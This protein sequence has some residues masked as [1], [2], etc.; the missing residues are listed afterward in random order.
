MSNQPKLLIQWQVEEI[1]AR[2]ELMEQI[3]SVKLLTPFLRLYLE[4]IALEALE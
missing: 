2:Q 4:S 1:L 3:K